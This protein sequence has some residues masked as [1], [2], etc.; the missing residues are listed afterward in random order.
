MR[1]KR[2]SGRLS[3]ESLQGA[4][5]HALSV[6]GAKY[7]HLPYHDPRHTKDVLRRITILLHALHSTLGD[8]FDARLIDLGRLAAVF[9]DIERDCDVKDKN[10]ND[11]LW[12][13]FPDKRRNRD[14]LIRLNEEVSVLRALAWMNDWNGNQ[15]GAFTR[16][17]ALIV[18]DAIMA[19]K[20]DWPRSP[21]PLA[22]SP[23]ALRSPMSA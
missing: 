4:K 12:K 13:L 18:R 21:R 17:D 16:D 10:L 1:P 23:P 15:P 6:I 7:G 5:E 9:H 22:W 8:R 11:D 14:G 19:T 2:R 20:A 3:A